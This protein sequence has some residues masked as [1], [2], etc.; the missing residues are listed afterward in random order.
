V[1][2]QKTL[3][4]KSSAGGITIL[5]FKLYYTAIAIKKNNMVLAQKQ[6]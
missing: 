5:D 6:M 4:K 2:A 3:N 1:D